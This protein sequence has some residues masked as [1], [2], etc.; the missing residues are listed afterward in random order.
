MSNSRDASSSLR[1]YLYQREYTV[2]VLLENFGTKCK[3]VEE[4]EVNNCNYEDITIIKENYSIVTYQLKYSKN[5]LPSLKDK[6]N[7]LFTTVLNP[8]NRKCETVYY[9]AYTEDKSNKDFFVELEN[10]TIDIGEIYENI[11]KYQEKK[12]CELGNKRDPNSIL[13]RNSLLEFNQNI[14]HYKQ[15]D[16][17]NLRNYRF[18]KGLDYDTLNLY[19]CEKIREIFNQSNPF[20]VYGIKGLILEELNSK[21]FNRKKDYVLDI[22]EFV[23]SIRN[24]IEENFGTPNILETEP[25]TIKEEKNILRKLITK[26]NLWFK[27]KFNSIKINH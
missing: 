7:G 20:I 2:K 26:V 27:T 13:K 22:D 25:I 14:N 6:N 21:I 5:Q 18:E 16:F 9:I 8:N 10:G 3:I 15:T 19:I 4:G 24:K 1:G 17:L 11:E 23:L 12:I